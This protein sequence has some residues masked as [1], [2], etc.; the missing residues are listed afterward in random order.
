L[1]LL[2][3]AL[4][5]AFSGGGFAEELKPILENFGGEE[6]ANALE[7][8][9]ELEQQISGM[10]GLFKESASESAAKSPEECNFPLAPI[11]RVA[12]GRI[13]G[14]LCKYTLLRI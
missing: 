8:A 3:L 7:E 6:A 12:D 11:V 5:L 14:A 1:Q 13:L 4:A 10:C 2:V 9:Q